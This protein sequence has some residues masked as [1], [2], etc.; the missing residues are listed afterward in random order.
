[1]FALLTL[2][3]NAL[4]IRLSALKQVNM[5]LSTPN[6]MLMQAYQRLYLSTDDLD[7]DGNAALKKYKCVSC[8]Y[9]FD[10]SIGFKKRFPPGLQL[11]LVNCLSLIVVF[12]LGTIFANLATFMCPVCGAAKDQFVEIKDDN[13]G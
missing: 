12:A 3:I 1:M 2:G 13:S 8:A 10:E 11:L 7:M 9:I 6:S 4:K 5:H